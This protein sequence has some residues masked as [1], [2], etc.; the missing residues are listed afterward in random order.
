MTGI[1]HGRLLLVT[2]AAGVLG[3]A[4]C[5]RIAAD[6]HRVLMM[7]IDAEGLR[8]RAGLVGEPAR[9][10]VADVGDL[11]AVER[12]CRSIRDAHGHVDTLV[13]NAGL[14]TGSGTE[15][16]SPDEWRRLMAVNLDGAFHLARALLPGMRERGFG[17]VVN[18]CSMAMKTGGLTAGTAYVASKGGLGALTFALARE[19]AAHGI[20]VNAVAPAYVRT[21]MVTEQLT[22]DQRQALLRRIPVGRFCEPEEVAELVAFLVSTHAGFITGEVIDINGGLHMD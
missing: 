3:T 8:T 19:T 10:V 20:T 9:P 7:D 17:R 18:V 21:P 1:G 12:A 14:L 15:E 6:G 13:N 16:T 5:R 22:H 4:I 2:G 11:A